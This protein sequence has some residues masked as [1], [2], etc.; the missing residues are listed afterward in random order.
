M[1]TGRYGKFPKPAG[2]TID[3]GIFYQVNAK[4]TENGCN[5]GPVLGL[6]SVVI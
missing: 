1:K 5:S 3:K 4:P 2:P 6:K